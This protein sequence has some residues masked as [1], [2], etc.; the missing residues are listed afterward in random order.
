MVERERH[1][2]SDVEDLVKRC[3][4]RIEKAQDRN[5]QYQRYVD[6]YFGTHK[7][8]GYQLSDSTGRPVLRTT[9]IR[10]ELQGRPGA[11][12][13]LAPIIDDFQSLKGILPTFR[14]LPEGSEDEQQEEA[15]KRSRI[16]RAMYDNSN[17]DVQ[18]ADAAFYLS[19]MGDCCYVLHPKFPDEDT[20]NLL[21]PPG[22]YINVI[23]PRL[24]YPAFRSGVYRNE[25]QDLYISWMVPA[26]TAWEEYGI[27]PGN[28]DE[29]QV[30]EYYS[31]HEKQTILAVHGG[32][33]RYGDPIM[34][35]LDFVPAQWVRNRQV[36]DR[37]AQSDICQVVDLQEEMA[38]QYHVMSDA[39]IEATYA[40]LVIENPE[41]I[42]GDRAVIGPGA[43][44]S[45]TTGG[46]VYRVD[47]IPPPQAAENLLAGT[48]Q[49]IQRGTGSAP[50]RTEGGIDRSNISGRA[51]HAMQGPMETRLSL[52]Q[53]LMGAA[54]VRL[55]AKILLMLYKLDGFKNSELTVYGM[56]GGDPT[57]VRFSGD[58]LGGWWRN[59]VEY[60]AMIGST[61]HERVVIFGQAFHD[62]IVTKKLYA[63]QLGLV[64][65][66]G[67]VKAAT[68]ERQ[69]D[70][71]AQQAMQPL[72]GGP[73]GLTPPDGPPG[74][75]AGG[76]PVAQ[77]MMSMAG[78]G[79]GGPP[80]GG[81]PGADAGSSPAGPPSAVQ[82]PP[83]GLPPFPP[84]PVAPTELGIANLPDI[85]D[86]AAMEQQALAS[87]PAATQAK[88]V[89][90]TPNKTGVL[91]IVSD[92]KLVAT[93]EVKRAF[94]QVG[95][96]A[97]VTTGG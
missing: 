24:A 41:K 90:V 76:Q 92:P 46:K 32:P 35:D 40:P 52:G 69:A 50:V 15:E 37:F 38:V 31:K 79:P 43:V 93:G 63:S 88:I 57:S 49:H 30:I 71:Q 47:P 82:P 28:D 16:L 83:P 51:V 42:A 68:A 75:G 87:L 86:L 77:G 73:S 9:E 3:G 74:A 60:D 61:R 65:P 55:N 58:E 29:V 20:D 22:V 1:A 91:V 96:K 78:G 45:T 23:D 48:M 56:H 17:M 89:S 21:E 70:M 80:P 67:E 62:G 95:M 6:M 10:D 25:L 81:P 85:P 8:R 54:Y 19:C 34:H 97:R 5:S 44:I 14:V 4:D 12:N 94:A 11:P 39:L 53:S 33:V 27:D 7:K 66:D 84:T 72:P 64:D 36:G 26:E 59:T 13:L 2:P 18:Q